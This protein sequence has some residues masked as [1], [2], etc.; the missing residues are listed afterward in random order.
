MRF[1]KKYISQD[2]KVIKISQD[3]K[4]YNHRFNLKREIPKK[5]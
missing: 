1:T 5:R 4:D 3:I 2:V